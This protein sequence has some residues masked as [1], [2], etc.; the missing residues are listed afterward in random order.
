LLFFARK[1]KIE[2]SQFNPLLPSSARN[3]IFF[4]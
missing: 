2:G 1:G 3:Q 4:F